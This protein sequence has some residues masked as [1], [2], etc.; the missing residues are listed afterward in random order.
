[1]A[2]DEIEKYLNI[3]FQISGLLTVILAVYKFKLFEVFKHRYSTEM[4]VKS[5]YTKS[6]KL[7]VVC[8]YVIHNTGEIPIRIDEV[9]LSF[10]KAEEKD[11]QIKCAEE[12]VLLNRV[13]R[14]DNPRYSELMKISAGEHAEF[15]IRGVFEKPGE[16]MFIYGNFSWQHNRDVAPY[17]HTLL[18][19]NA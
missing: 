3:V 15:P 13:F 6:G 1:M 18:N 7:Y 5:K 10:Y 4:L 2:L 11:Q 8:T 19:E 16:A 9:N 12:T 17:H 14:A